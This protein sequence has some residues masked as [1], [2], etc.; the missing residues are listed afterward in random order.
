V[1]PVTKRLVSFNQLCPENHTL[2][3]WLETED[4]SLVEN[5]RDGVNGAVRESSDEVKRSGENSGVN[6]GRG[7]KIL[8]SG[9]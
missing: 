3:L 4:F 9:S 6:T 5:Q 8:K 2:L 7:I 1:R